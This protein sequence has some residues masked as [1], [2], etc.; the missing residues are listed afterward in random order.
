MV[1]EIM[2]W[3]IIQTNDGGAIKSNVIDA[4][5]DRR[6]AWDEACKIFG[7]KTNYLVDKLEFYVIVILPGSHP[8][9]DYDSISKNEG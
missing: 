3:T 9:H 4:S 6:M 7:Y 2:T 8:V 5:H 1:G